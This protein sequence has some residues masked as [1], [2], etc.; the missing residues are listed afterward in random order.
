MSAQQYGLIEAGGTKFVL[1]ISKADGAIVARHRIPTTMPEETLSAMAAWFADKG[2]LTAIGVATFGPVELD[3]SSPNW[4][5][6]LKTPKPGWT[7]ADLLAPLKAQ[8][9]CPIALDTDVNAAALAEAQRGAGK[10]ESSV[11]YFTVGTGIGGGAVINGKTLCGK[12]HPEMGHIRLARH[13]DDLDFAGICP[14]H[15]DCLEGLASGPAIKARWGKSLSELPGDHIAHDIISYYL[16]Q[17]VVTMQAIFEPGKVIFGGGVMATPNLIS[18]VREQAILLGGGYFRTDPAA[19][20]VPPALGD[21]A[22]LL[23]AL[24]IALSSTSVS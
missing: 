14:F 3:R 13:P 6:I 23:G 4:G 21:D 20:V 10:G 5:H 22:G 24:A 8:F 7:D 15:G 18:Q 1:G 9:D 17:T 12:G 2:A 19:M 16:A 11:L